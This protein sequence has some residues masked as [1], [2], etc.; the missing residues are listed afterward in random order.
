M[1]IQ[2]KC[3]AVN[4]AAA[5]GRLKKNRPG[6]AGPVSQ[7]GRRPAIHRS[8]PTH[9]NLRCRLPDAPPNGQAP[10]CTIFWPDAASSGKVSKRA[11]LLL[12]QRRNRRA[13]VASRQPRQH[14]PKL[15]AIREISNPV[16]VMP[17]VCLQFVVVT[18]IAAEKVGPWIDKLKPVPFI[19]PATEPTA[20]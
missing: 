13:T 18:A 11:K 8:N 5:A 9:P 2:R 15:I 17:I 6:S 3:C 12:P 14:L 4:W 20:E 19:R 1:H 7:W 16:G 10:R